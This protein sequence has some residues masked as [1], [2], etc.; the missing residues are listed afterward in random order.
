[1]RLD[2]AGDLDVPVT[3]FVLPPTNK[4]LIKIG[5]MVFS[6]KP[7]SEMA[8]IICGKQQAALGGNASPLHCCMSSFSHGNERNITGVGVL[9]CFCMAI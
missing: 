3:C 6:E 1:M 5:M 2:L 4:G 9:F 7:R 8:A